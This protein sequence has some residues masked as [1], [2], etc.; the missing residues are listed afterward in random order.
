VYEDSLKTDRE[1]AQFLLSKALL[2]LPY[3]TFPELSLNLAGQMSVTFSH[4]SFHAP[5]AGYH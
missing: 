3:I 2:H 4:T 5:D 1:S